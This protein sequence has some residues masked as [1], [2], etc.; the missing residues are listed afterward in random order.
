LGKVEKVHKAQEAP[1]TRPIKQL[2][3]NWCKTN[4][5]SYG[6]DS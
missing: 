4:R 5:R 3:F 6:K 1:F 2:S